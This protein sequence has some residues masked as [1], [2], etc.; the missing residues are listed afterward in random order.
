MTTFPLPLADILGHWGQYAVY[1]V[2]GFG[3][4]YVLEL[5]G[6]GNSKRLAAQFYLKDMTVLKVMF[7]GIV[8]A[9]LGIFAA[10]AL[11]LLDYNLLWVNPTYLVPGIVGGL[12]MGV[13]FI[14]GGFCP[15]TSVVA[16]VTGK[17]DGIVFLLG[18]LVGIFF[19][20]ESVGLFTDFFNSSYLGRF[21]L[22]DLFGVDAGVV[23]VGVVLMA[24]AAFAFAEWSEQTFG[25][26]SWRLAPMWRYTA[27]GVTL[28][29]ALGVMFVG[30]PNAAD[31]W[32]RMAEEKEGQLATR[33]VQIHPAELLA[34]MDNDRIILNMLDVRSET[35]FN[36]F[37]LL[38][39]QHTPDVSAIVKELQTM[40]VNTVF[41][42]MSNDESAATEAWKYLVSE[43]V[44]NVYILEGGINHW[45]DTYGKGE[46]ER[47][48]DTRDD[49]LAYFFS[50]AYGSRYPAAYPHANEFALEYTPKVVLRTKAGAGGGGCG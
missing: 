34:L 50:A 41:V 28:L 8:I 15:G 12:V 13:G 24:I 9:A 43:G 44:P 1:I 22:Q 29:I 32:A 45:L 26:T 3:F 16:S 38:D 37:H 48:A 19:F 49:E 10:S 4:G 25:G 46:Y 6:F 17:L 40:P 20:G 23:L 30:Q 42:L 21:T 5:A 18:V 39:A 47:I 31:R 33:A 11:G 14:I 27:A 7:T 36:R 2:I 35:D